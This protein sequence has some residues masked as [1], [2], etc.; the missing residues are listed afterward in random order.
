LRS[1]ATGGDKIMKRFI[2][3]S[4][5]AALLVAGVVAAAL[6]GADRALSQAAN[7][8][9]FTPTGKEFIEVT[10]RARRLSPMFRSRRCAMARSICS[11]RLRAAP[12]S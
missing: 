2:R 12:R 10:R 6:D 4:L 8:I 5:V 3:Y 1:A 7:Q 11:A 9:L